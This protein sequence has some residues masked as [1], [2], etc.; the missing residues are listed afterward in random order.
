MKQFSPLVGFDHPEK[1]TASGFVDR[2]F[3]DWCA[4]LIQGSDDALLLDVFWPDEHFQQ[5]FK[6]IAILLRP[7][8]RDPIE[9]LT[10]HMIRISS[11][12]AD[13][14]VGCDKEFPCA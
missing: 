11:H 2:A 14:F 3:A 1:Q 13:G 5:R 6:G 8:V 10:R 12:L 4:N 9:D 7:P